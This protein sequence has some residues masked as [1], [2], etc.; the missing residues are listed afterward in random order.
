MSWWWFV[1]SKDFTAK[2]EAP[3]LIELYETYGRCAFC[4]KMIAK[5][6]LVDLVR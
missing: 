3:L 5:I 1:A 2:Y 4:T 6:R